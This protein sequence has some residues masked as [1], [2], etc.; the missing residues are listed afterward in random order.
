MVKWEEPRPPFRTSFGCRTWSVAAALLPTGQTAIGPSRHT[1]PC[2]VSVEG[3][4]A[5]S[6]TGKSEVGG[7]K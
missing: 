1:H 4:F 5:C 7:G 2:V 3:G 6:K